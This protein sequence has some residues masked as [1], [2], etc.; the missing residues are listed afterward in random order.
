MSFLPFPLS[1]F[2][3][4]KK[5]TS[6]T[7]LTFRSKE[8]A[9]SAMQLQALGTPSMRKKIGVHKLGPRDQIWGC[10]AA[11]PTRGPGFSRMTGILDTATA[12]PNSSV[13]KGNL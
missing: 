5:A 4:L 9:S 11:W 6:P 2:L 10:G 1:L 8:S 3:F 7:M 13:N 12:F